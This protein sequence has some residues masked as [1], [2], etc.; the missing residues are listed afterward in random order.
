MASL[1][2][3]HAADPLPGHSAHGETFNE[4][5]RQA[6]VLIEGCGKVSFPATTKS[7]TAQQFIDQGVGQIHGFWYYEAERSFRQA[8]T[9]D[10]DC[11]IAY[12][13]CAMANVNNEKR[14]AGFIAEA[15]KRKDKASKREQA[16]IT[17]LQTFYADLKKDKKVRYTTFIKDLEDIIHDNPEDIEA[18]AFLAWAIWKA[19]DAGVTMVSRE[20]V[21]AIVQQVFAKAPMHPAHHYIIHLWDDTKPSRA[22]ASAALCGQTSPG[23]AHMWHMPGHTFS[24]TSRNE[25]AAWQQE[26]ANRVDH[27]YMIRTRVLPDQIHNYAHNAEWLIRTY[28]QLGQADKAVGLAKNMVELPRHPEW[29]TF[30]KNRSSSFYGRNRLLDTL[31]EFEKW[32]ELTALDGTAYL[33]V[34]QNPSFEA[35]RLRALGIAAFFKGDKAGVQKRL[36]EVQKL[37]LKTEEKTKPAPK[38]PNA[39][40]KKKE[41]PTTLASLDTSKD[42]PKAGDTKAEES[43]KDAPVSPA[44]AKP[45]DK[46]K[47]DKSPA[48]ETAKKDEASPKDKTKDTAAKSED[49][50]R[51]DDKNKPNATVTNAIAEL[52]ALV[53]MLDNKPAE[54]VT[55]LLDQ[56][57]DTPK[58][59]L[60]RYQLKIGN[61]DKAVTLANQLP[62][63]APGLAI[64]IDALMQCGKTDDAKKQFATARKTASLLDASL[65]MSKRLDELAVEFGA[66]KNWRQPTAPRKDSGVH[67]SLDSLGPLHWH[68]MTSPD[69]LLSDAAGK[70]VSLK[71]YAGK[72]VVVIFY[73]GST[74][75][76]CMQQL[77]AFTTAAKDYAAEGIEIVAIGSEPP[78]ELSSTAA[79]CDVKSG[80]PFTLL[81]DADLKSF[82]AWRCYD[83]FE[84]APLHGTFLIDAKGQT[85]WLDVSYT[86]F[87]D[88]KFLLGEAKR[89]LKFE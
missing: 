2:L 15:A 87:Q 22:L 83:D 77:K 39:P 52:Q 19:K 38:T 51:K 5:P 36:A 32:D 72:P 61:K 16:W 78:A 29:N 12:W 73:L 70:Q 64:R 31:L 80:A 18:K 74:C 45:E 60:V 20:S 62:N 58:E 6:A 41:D 35:T 21:D 86:P 68:P 89:L 75:E 33:D 7:T 1:S 30:E 42:K 25:D 10:P 82:K 48:P 65:P 69:F 17:A 55:K 27:A 54:E 53:A 85:R 56:A 79:T 8:L 11:A 44:P 81:S 84:K 76:H 4:G 50:K 43:K 57:K 23:I 13:G 9:L 66:D 88:A 46:A 59:R 37:K 24:K 47:P 26:A 63:D 49:D 67:P 3:L 71:D 34:A 14:A 28:N 40:E